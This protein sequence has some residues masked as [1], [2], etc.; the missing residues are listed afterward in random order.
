VAGP[1][2]SRALSTTRDAAGPR[3]HLLAGSLS[4][5]VLVVVTVAIALL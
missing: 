2:T 4:V 3:R 1:L 5:A